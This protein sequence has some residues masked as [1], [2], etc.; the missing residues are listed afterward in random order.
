MDRR[1]F[2]GTLA[3]VLGLLAAPLAAA[4][5][6]TD[7]LAISVMEDGGLLIPDSAE[8]PRYAEGGQWTETRGRSSVQH[9]TRHF[10]FMPA[11][12]PPVMELYVTRDLTEEAPDGAFEIGL[13]G[14]FLR[15]FG[16]GTGFRYEA[17]TFEDVVVGGVRLKRCRVE[18]A[19]A[20]RHVWLY[21]YLL[22]RRPSLTF[23]TVRPR[24]DAGV[25][26]EDYLTRVRLK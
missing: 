17:P 26:I 1:V 20:G 10:M 15:G 6:E 21:A 18:L 8:V 23:L 3:G 13:V 5:T 9:V 11:S 2:M 16:S 19:K 12:G 4:A 22:L 14:G 25:A 24:P 7:V